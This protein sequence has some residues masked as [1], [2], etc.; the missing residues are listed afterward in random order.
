MDTTNND[1]WPVSKF[2][3]L[4]TIAGGSVTGDIS[5][6]EVSGLDQETD[7]MEYRHG[8][9]PAFGTIKKPG[10]V[11]S[12]NVVCKKGIFKNDKRITD[13]F[14]DIYNKKYYYE[15]SERMQITIKLLDEAGNPIMTWEL[16][17]AFPMK[18]TGT[19][20]KSDASEIAVESL[21]FAHEGIK[22]TMV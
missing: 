10:L 14:N 6:Q 12:T 8:D 20:L 2:H 13:M 21:E 17:N 3:F 11:K 15:K 22:A 18:L 16:T 19:D 4:V 7:V 1:L 5:F 9:N